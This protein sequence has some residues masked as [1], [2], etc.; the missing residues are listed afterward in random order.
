MKY[1]YLL[2][3]SLFLVACGASNEKSEQAEG[4]EEAKD[5]LEQLEETLPVKNTDITQ[6]ML[7]EFVPEGYKIVQ[8]QLGNLNMDD[9]ND[10]ILVIGK[11]EEE[12]EEEAEVEST[13]S[14]DDYSENEEKRPLLILTMNE[15]GALEEKARNNNV[16][17][18]PDCGGVMGDP[19]AEAGSIVIKNGYFSI[20]SMGGSSTRWVRIITFKY[21]TTKKGWFLHKD[22]MISW[23]THE[24]DSEEET[25]YSTKDFGVVPFEAYN[26]VN[27]F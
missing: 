20:E 16:I 12:A 26:Y 13:G 10:V 5:I 22:G 23:S 18:C 25:V 17:M 27:R 3:I 6:E 11:A 21:N 2:T 15:K 24:A 8:W 19:F 1:F 7:D 4:R 14:T 9:K